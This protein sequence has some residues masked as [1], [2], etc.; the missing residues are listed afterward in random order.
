MIPHVL[1]HVW[2]GPKPVPWELVTPWRDFHPG[3]EFRL[4]Q[5]PDLHWLRHQAA[6]DA[7]I[8]AGTW[9]G[10]ANIAR[11]EILEREGGVYVDMDTVP[12]R[13]LGAHHLRAGLFAGYVQPRPE[14]PELIGNAYIGAIPHHPVLRTAS[15]LIA[16]RRRLDPPWIETGVL[17]FSRAVHSWQRRGRADIYVAPTHVF[18]PVD[19]HGHE[20][21]AGRGLTYARH[22]WGSTIR[23]EWHYGDPT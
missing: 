18:Y 5:E 12:L 16:A 21:P 6:F 3:W 19:K 20:A 15:R 7:Y 4:W 22:L 9:H 11:I 1:H 23:S 2:V 10:A 13:P 8:R 17:P 14:Y